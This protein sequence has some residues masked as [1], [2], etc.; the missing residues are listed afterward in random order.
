MNSSPDRLRATRTIPHG[1]PASSVAISGLPSPAP[2]P[3]QQGV[4]IK[5]RTFINGWKGLPRV[6]LTPD[7]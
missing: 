5:I 4:L 6:W 7:V 3:A 2:S 1:L